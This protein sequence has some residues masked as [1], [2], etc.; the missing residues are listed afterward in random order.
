M[1]QATVESSDDGSDQRATCQTLEVIS[2]SIED[3][4]G[5]LA[6]WPTSQGVRGGL[7]RGMEGGER[8]T[9]LP[10]LI[11]PPIFLSVLPG[12]P[13]SFSSSPPCLL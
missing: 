1:K 4:Y 6:A 7:L 8:E 2:C 12:L 10:L 3:F 5:I 9:T 13:P 11:F